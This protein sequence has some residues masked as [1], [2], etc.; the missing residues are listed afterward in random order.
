MW[1][2][3][4]IHRINLF[5]HANVKLKKKN[6]SSVFI[7]IQIYRKICARF[8]VLLFLKKNNQWAKAVK[9]QNLWSTTVVVAAVA[10]GGGPK[11]CRPHP[12]N[13]HLAFENVVRF[14][15]TIQLVWNVVDVLCKLNCQT[16]PGECHFLDL[17][18]LCSDLS[19]FSK[20]IT[21]TV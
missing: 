5:C 16:K 10:A 11:I 7:F 13:N 14:F 20:A 19:L 12:H 21:G 3:L 15:N 17:P 8:D 9:Q 6:P 18:L 2:H 1:L 4:H